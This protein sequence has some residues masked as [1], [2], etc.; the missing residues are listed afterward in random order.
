MSV[1]ETGEFGWKFNKGAS[2]HR[3]HGAHSNRKGPSALGLVEA[4]YSNRFCQVFVKG[5]GIAL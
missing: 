3:T 4:Q 2:R 5:R 1:R